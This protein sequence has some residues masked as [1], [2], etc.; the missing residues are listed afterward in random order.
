M[1]VSESPESSSPALGREL[2]DET[3]RYHQDQA[4]E[5]QNRVLHSVSELVAERC[6]LLEVCAPWDSPLSEAVQRASSQAVGI[7]LHNGYDLSTKAGLRKALATLRELRPRYVHV[8]PPCLPFSPLSHT[9]Q[10]TPKQIQDMLQKR[11]HGSLILQNCY[12][13]IQVQQQELQGESGTGPDC[14]A[15]GEQPLRAISWKEPSVKRM[16]QLCGGSR[17]RCDGCSF[18]MKSRRTGVPIQKCLGWFSSHKG[19][20]KALNRTC[21][22]GT[23]RHASI[24]G[25]EVSETAV[26]PKSL[27]K[28]FAKALMQEREECWQR[29]LAV[30]GSGEEPPVTE[31]P[32]PVEGN[33]EDEEPPDDMNLEGLFEQP[34]PAVQEEQPG[35]EEQPSQEA[36]QGNWGSKILLEKLRIIH[37]SLGHPSNA[38]LV[39]MLRDARASE[40]MMKAASEYQCPHCARRGH[41]KPHCT[42]QVRQATRKREVVSVDTFWWH[43]PHKDE[44]GNP[45]SNMFLA[46]PG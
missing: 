13:I 34:P 33:L 20:R 35:D 31:G 28:A 19:V 8:S 3:K 15:G 7:G 27:C 25:R 43:S 21:Q 26:Y 22:H 32:P 4:L 40:E 1:K 45:L 38:V 44:M 42:S 5:Y 9:N 29:C 30:T 23:Q 2:C 12:K 36:E 14:H 6:D 17:S 46:S 39:R 16:I 10:R 11:A 18:G 41:A 24:A 37:A